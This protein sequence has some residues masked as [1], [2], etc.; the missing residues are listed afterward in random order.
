MPASFHPAPVRPWTRPTAPTCAISCSFISSH[1]HLTLHLTPHLPPTALTKSIL[2]FSASSSSARLA[3]NRSISPL[4]KIALVDASRWM[5]AVYAGSNTISGSTLTAHA[6]SALRAVLS[7]GPHKSA[8]TSLLFFRTSERNLATVGCGGGGSAAPAAAVREVDERRSLGRSA[9]VEAATA[10]AEALGGGAAGLR[11]SGFVSFLGPIEIPRPTPGVMCGTAVG[12]G[13][14]AKLSDEGD[15]CVGLPVNT[16]VL[17]RPLGV[18]ALEPSSS[19]RLGFGLGELGELRLK[20]VLDRCSQPGEPGG[21]CECWR[22]GETG[23][24]GGMDDGD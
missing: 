7:H 4:T 24:D 1:R 11:A 23:G 6:C 21:S 10:G 20:S 5:T 19:L 22:D 18:L 9:A 12:G 16:T 8:E 17:L 2:T 3:S 15:S 13:G 14:L